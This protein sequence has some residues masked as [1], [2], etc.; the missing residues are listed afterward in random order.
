MKFFWVGTDKRN[1]IPYGIN[2]N[3]AVDLRYANRMNAYRIPNCCVVDMK[4]PMEV[5]F[6]DILI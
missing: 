3:R 5:F 1:H 6:P 2:V 4:T